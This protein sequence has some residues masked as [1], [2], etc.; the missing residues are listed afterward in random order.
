M[1]YESAL[2]RIERLGPH[3]ALLVRVLAGI[4]KDR[5][6]AGMEIVGFHYAD[7]LGFCMPR[8]KRVVSGW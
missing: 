4:V 3:K 2:K 6:R 1:R 8:V 5:D 7:M